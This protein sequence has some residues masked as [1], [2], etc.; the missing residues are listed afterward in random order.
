FFYFR[1][2]QSSGRYF[3]GQSR[4][5]KNGN[6][7]RQ[8]NSADCCTGLFLAPV[9]ARTDDV[10]SAIAKFQEALKHDSSFNIDPKIHAQQVAEAEKLVTE[11]EKLAKTGDYDGTI[12][13]LKQALEIDPSLNIAPGQKAT[14][15]SLSYL[16]DE[17]EKLAK[18][19]DIEGARRELVRHKKWLNFEPYEKAKKL[20]APQLIKDGEKFAYE[21]NIREAIKAYAKV[22]KIPDK[23][24]NILCLLGS[25][26]GYADDVM[27]ACEQAVQKP[28]YYKNSRGIARALTGDIEGA[29]KD[30]ESFSD[31]METTVALYSD[32]KKAELAEI[33]S[34]PKRWIDDL[35][36][37]ENPFTP[38]EILALF[39]ENGMETHVVCYNLGQVAEREKEFEKAL[40]WYERIED[41]DYYFLTAQERIGTILVSQ[42]F[43]D[44]A[45]KHYENIQ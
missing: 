8:S 17:A 38:E 7:R 44:N 43:S 4:T 2:R 32:D 14:E 15:L 12:S 40:S 36:K 39:N 1:Q 22:D 6:N 20:A 30:F 42:G 9:G 23:S 11:G 31:L 35:R 13:V 34:R 41:G 25:L 26:Y 45:L 24:L 10:D 37:G 19:G 21:G 28:N 18:A 3:Q 29:I 33:V 5:Q 27:Y 16:I